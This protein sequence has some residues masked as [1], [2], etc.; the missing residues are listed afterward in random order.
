MSVDYLK[1]LKIHILRFHRRRPKETIKVLLATIAALEEEIDLLQADLL[2]V[3]SKYEAATKNGEECDQYLEQVRFLAA[4]KVRLEGRNSRRERKM[5]KLRLLKNRITE[6]SKTE[7][8]RMKS[9][10]SKLNK[11]DAEISDLKSSLQQL[12]QGSDAERV[13]HLEKIAELTEKLREKDSLHQT[14]IDLLN[15]Q[16]QR[17]VDERDAKA[18][19]IWEQHLQSGEDEIGGFKSDYGEAESSNFNYYNDDDNEDDY[20]SKETKRVKEFRQAT[21]I[22]SQYKSMAQ[23]TDI[24]DLTHFE[25]LSVLGTGG[26]QNE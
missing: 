24:V 13:G 18:A 25:L 8:Q 26:E 21:M 22:E 12:K 14:Q 10:V 9:T 6:N 15:T 3:N 16:W 7:K 5:R 2:K 20:V 17:T 4:E 23:S 19:E 11:K 1:N